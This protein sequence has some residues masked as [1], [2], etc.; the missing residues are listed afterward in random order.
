MTY[1]I[2]GPPPFLLRARYVNHIDSLGNR[3]IN[4]KKPD[5][6]TRGNLDRA[7]VVPDAL[8]CLFGEVESESLPQ[9]T[10]LKPSFCR[11]LPENGPFYP[12]GSHVFEF[13]AN[14]SD[15]AVII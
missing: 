3:S 15:E 1:P 10:T 4:K 11:N 12:P 2:D 7:N 13:L 14:S 9:E 6:H 8:S 5:K